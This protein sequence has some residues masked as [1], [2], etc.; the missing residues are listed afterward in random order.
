M[1][2]DA[3][4]DRSS[5]IFVAVPG[6]EQEADALRAMGG[7]W[8]WHDRGRCGSGV[9]PVDKVTSEGCFWTTDAADA[10]RV[11]GDGVRTEAAAM[12]LQKAKNAV[13]FRIEWIDSHKA[14]RAVGKYDRLTE[15]LHRVGG[16]RWHPKTC[17]D[18]C[19]DPCSMKDFFG[20]WTRRV[21]SVI[22]LEDA[23]D[24]KA[25]EV[26]ERMKESIKVSRAEDAEV[27][28]RLADGMELR[29]Y[30]KVGVRW[31]FDRKMCLIADDPGLGK[32]PQA[33]GAVLMDPSAKRIL[34][35]CPGNVAPN[36]AD[37]IQRW[38]PD[39]PR[40]V[41]ACGGINK[42]K[43]ER[44]NAFLPKSAEERLWIV[45]SF[46]SAR[47]SSGERPRFV[48]Q[49]LQSLP[50]FDVVIVDEAHRIG[51]PTSQQTQ[52]C[53]SHAKRAN[54]AMFLTGTPMPNNVLDMQPVLG[55]MDPIVFD[56]RAFANRFCEWES[57]GFGSSPKGMR[58][59]RAAELQDLLRSTV[60]LRRTKGSV[61]K[62][63]P[64]KVYRTQ[65]FT[66]NKK[67]RS[68]LPK[69]KQ[70]EL[71]LQ[72]ASVVAARKAR[73]EA[74]RSED[75]AAMLEAISAEIDAT[76]AAFEQIS[77]ARSVE[78]M[79]KVKDSLEYIRRRTGDHRKAIVFAWHREVAEALYDGLGGGARC[80]LL[81]GEQSLKQRSGFVKRFQS[82]QSVQFVV[83]TIA[84]SA[85][86]ITLTAA[87]LVIFVEF[88]W[89][90]VK[91]VQSEDRAHRLT[92]TETVE[93]DY[94]VVDG[95]LDAYVA[96]LIAKKAKYAALALDRTHKET[97]A[98]DL[99]FRADEV[100]FSAHSGRG[101]VSEKRI[102]RLASRISA[103]QA[104]SARASVTSA[105]RW[106]WM[107]Q[108]AISALLEL[109]DSQWTVELLKLSQ[110]LSSQD[111]SGR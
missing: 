45:T 105:R 25:R 10:S 83:A 37:E 15:A 65:V 21:A 101:W 58:E 100:V 99:G 48:G 106:D 108:G 95:S 47:V 54:R 41:V 27:D 94:L 9:C 84:S 28:V 97:Q 69:K 66:P 52:A 75:A 107:E 60:M 1:I 19:A 50:P 31:A 36:W 23:C 34:V 46:D 59:D 55:L 110:S 17:T 68:L 70:I 80:V 33:I 43:L 16:W 51:S 49:K 86:G 85:E 74:E 38:S 63:L 26:L 57:N 104:A 7:S 90:A 92:Q 77:A 96:S 20:W 22:A 98:I 111:I 82:D 109:D 79:L 40:V 61:L 3:G 102:P 87:S 4:T 72:T 5:V 14:F 56:R 93:I 42:E 76:A 81:Q 91:L 78:G 8:R 44:E 2:L 32:T 53:L 29:P 64:P 11:A 18:R 30:Q 73:E 12:A 24:A 6:S 88:P 103:D 39:A 67:Q 89:T 13:P 62:E 35:I 71:A